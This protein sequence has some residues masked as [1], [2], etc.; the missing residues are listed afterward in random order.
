MA[1]HE[2]IRAYLSELRVSL[3]G[4]DGAR[5]I[6][7]EAEDHLLEAVGHLMH[8]GVDQHQ[9]QV[10]TLARFGSAALVSRVCIIESRKGAA[11][12]TIFT[13]RAGLAGVVTPVLL[14]L[15]LLGNVVFW[16][17]KRGVEG[18][19]HGL[20]SGL[21]LPLGLCTFLFS[22]IGLRSRH[23]GLGRFG[24]AALVVVLVTPFA[25]A[26][27]GWGAGYVAL[28]LLALAVTLL[29][30]GMLRA[31]VLPVAPL[32]GVIA[33]PIVFIA[34]A[35]VAHVTDS[36]GDISTWLLLAPLSSPILALSWLGWF[37]WNEPALDRSGGTT[38]LAP[39]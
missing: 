23:R 37:Q 35:A 6:L 2:L 9:A 29:G 25:A 1:D 12:S 38:P 39:A 14:A 33:G 28:L 15:G 10:R 5:P 8:E 26:P 36:T 11:V 30:V 22:L 19:L 7:E 21:L 24:T 17:D 34:T 13:R 27:F 3:A 31:G 16:H 18:T 4:F 32:V 20:S